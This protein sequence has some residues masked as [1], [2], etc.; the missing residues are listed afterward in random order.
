MKLKG[1]KRKKMQENQKLKDKATTY[2]DYEWT[3][4]TQKRKFKYSLWM[5]LT[6][7]NNKLMSEGKLYKKT[8]SYFSSSCQ[9]CCSADIS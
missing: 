5:S 3:S 6:C 1:E 2:K 8:K 9:Y 4:F 7:M